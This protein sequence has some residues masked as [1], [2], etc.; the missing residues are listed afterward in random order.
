MAPIFLLLVLLQTP[1]MV[2]EAADSGQLTLQLTVV[3]FKL[4]E[5]CSWLWDGG[6]STSEI[7][8]GVQ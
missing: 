5:L 4:W 7:R 1:A 2:S 6:P 8:D 3:L